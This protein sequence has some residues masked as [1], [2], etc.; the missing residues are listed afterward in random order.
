MNPQDPNQ[1]DNAP[2]DTSFGQPDTND[3]QQGTPAPA[4]DSTTPDADA[5]ALQAIES[6]ESELPQ[7]PTQAAPVVAVEPTA[8]E[9]PTI[10]QPEVAG[11]SDAQPLTPD[12]SAAPKTEPASPSPTP[13][14]AS[15]AGLAAAAGAQ[16]GQSF[17][18]QPAPSSAPAPFGE[19]KKKSKLVIVLAI[20]VFGLA[21]GVAGFFI[22]QSMTPAT[23][24]APVQTGG[25]APSKGDDS[26][27]Q[28]ESQVVQP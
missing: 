27:I 20:V 18:A 21:A 24:T 3:F 16:A 26:D 25:D 11:V 8:V 10:S 6:L 17:S 28:V 23:S 5:A 1:Q 13:V 22:W 14:E 7:Q 15:A 4:S 9:T 2:Q 19:T 12:Y